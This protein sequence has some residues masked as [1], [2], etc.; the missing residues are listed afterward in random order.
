MSFD[1]RVVLFATGVRDVL[2]AINGLKS[3]YGISIHHCPYCDAW[4]H[5]GERLTVIGKKPT[6]LA[7]TLKSWSK[8]VTVCTNGDELE[9]TA[10]KQLSS[11]ET[12]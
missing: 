9:Q 6:E 1:T 12:G 3:F 11:H 4:E 10:A 8:K 5:S 2:P 7:L